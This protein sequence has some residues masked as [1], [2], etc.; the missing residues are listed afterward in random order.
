M[1]SEGSDGNENEY[2]NNFY[3]N[4]RYI[5]EDNNSYFLQNQTFQKNYFISN[6]KENQNNNYLLDIYLLN[7]PLTDNILEK[8]EKST[9]FKSKP[10]K[11]ECKENEEPTYYSIN[12]ILDLL[13]DDKFLKIR[14]T[15]KSN[16]NYNNIP[17]ELEFSKEKKKYLD[18]EDNNLCV[19]IKKQKE[20]N[21]LKKKRGRTK[22]NKLNIDEHDKMSPDN[23]IKKIKAKIFNYSIVFLNNLIN[24]KEYKLL[25]LDYSIINRLNKEKDLQYLKMSLKDLLSKDVS[26]KFFNN[27][28]K[29]KDKDYNKNQIKDILKN[30][31]DKTIQFAFNMTLGDWLDIFTLKKSVKQ[32]VE[33]YDYLEKNI[34]CDKIE[35]SFPEIGHL[36]NEIN[37]KNSIEYFTCFVFYLYNYERWFY[38]KHGRK[39]NKNLNKIN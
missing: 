17:S 15:I 20:E 26:S 11:E 34:D 9:S 31:A 37:D 27:S 4:N 32:I 7:K 36:L 25:K 30:E 16:E 14:N 39:R 24:I 22:N 5:I 13:Y 29:D 8:E 19:L 10:I 2:I 28:S 6:G 21:Q 35:K 1:F 3:E 38:I 33:K 23:I 12:N 18:N